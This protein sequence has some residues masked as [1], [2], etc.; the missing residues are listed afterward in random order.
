MTKKTIIIDSDNIYNKAKDLKF[1]NDIAKILRSKGYR[2]LVND[3]IGPNEHCNDIYKYGYENVCVFCIFGGCDSGM[4][5]DM[6]SKWY[7]NYLKQYNN[8]FSVYLVVVTV[9]CSMIWAANGIRII[10]SNTIIE[11]Y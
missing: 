8:R 9:V 1:I 4:F 7:Q 2:V 10:L 5:Y 11:L 3:D 6:S